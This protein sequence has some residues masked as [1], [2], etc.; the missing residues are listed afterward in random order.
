VTAPVFPGLEKAMLSR[1][2]TNR[3]HLFLAA[4]RRREEAQRHATAA[5]EAYA[6]AEQDA[7]DAGDRL[8]YLA[9]AS[10]VGRV[11]VVVDLRTVLQIQ[12]V[13]PGNVVGAQANVSILPVETVD[14]SPPAEA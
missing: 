7:K 3:I 12:A 10:P 6:L 2:D 9:D 8:R 13:G 1:F 5:S 4:E 14:P 11:L